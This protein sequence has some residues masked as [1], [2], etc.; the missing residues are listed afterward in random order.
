MIGPFCSVL[1]CGFD[2]SE[3]TVFNYLC[4]VVNF[5]VCLGSKKINLVLPMAESVW[6]D[7]L[8]GFL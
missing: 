4:V 1:K 7:I 3:V 8:L 2:H 6:G 5:F